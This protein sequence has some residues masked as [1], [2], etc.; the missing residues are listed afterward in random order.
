MTCWFVF[1]FCNCQVVNSSDRK[2]IFCSIH[3]DLNFQ[4]V[5]W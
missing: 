5:S 3:S 2:V 1:Y 4:K